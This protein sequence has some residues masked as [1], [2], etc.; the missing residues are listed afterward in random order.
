[1]ENELA[2]EVLQ[3][4]QNGMP[5]LRPIGEESVTKKQKRFVSFPTLNPIKILGYQSK[6][7]DASESEIVK[8]RHPVPTCSICKVER[9][10]KDDKAYRSVYSLLETSLYAILFSL[11]LILELRLCYLIA[12]CVGVRGRLSFPP[13]VCDYYPQEIYKSHRKSY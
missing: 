9:M 8:F 2:N 10:T 13:R 4:S 12:W 6:K 11:I 5:A 3:N 1:M 7:S